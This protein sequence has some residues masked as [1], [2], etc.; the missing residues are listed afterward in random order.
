VN[1]FLI[2]GAWQRVFMWGTLLLFFAVPLIAIIVWIIRRVMNVRSQNRYLGWIFGGLWTLGWVAAA[3]FF[4]SL[5]KDFRT[6]QQT[7]TEI[8]LARPAMNKIVVQVPGSPILYSGNFNWLNVNDEDGWDIT[9]D[10]LTLS[11]I[12]LNIKASEDSVYHVTLTRLS[13]GYSRANAMQRAEKIEYTVTSR[14]SLLL[15]DN[16]F[17]LNSTDKFRNQRVVVEIRIPVGRQIRFD[18]TVA[19]K[20]NPFNVRVT[21]SENY[22]RRRN[23]SRRDWNYEWDNNSYQDWEADTDYYM[24]TNGKLKKVGDA[25]SKVPEKPVNKTKDSLLREYQ[26]KLDS[27]ESTGSENE[28]EALPKQEETVQKRE[29]GGELPTPMPVP[30]VPTIF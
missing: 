29:I 12:R 18:R 2:D 15:L 3:L 30:F 4:S 22:G 17:S 24:A 21:E 23:W 5:A 16:G 19:D 10:S 1:A 11:N 28:D 25:E 20:L 9:E 13:N 14:D 26:R 27:I 6:T 7:E 8:S